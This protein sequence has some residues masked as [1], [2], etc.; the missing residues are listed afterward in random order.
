MVSLPEI[1]PLSVLS[2]Y[3]VRLLG[4][5]PS[6]FKLQGTNTYLVGAPGQPER[7]LIDASEGETEYISML[8][9][10]LNI[11]QFK[12]VGIICTHWHIDHVGGIHSIRKTVGYDVPVYK[13]P[14]YTDEFEPTP[15]QDGDILALAG[16][17]LHVLFTPGHA[18]DHVCLY[19]PVDNNSMF[20]GDNVLGHG[21]TFFSAYATYMKSLKKMQAVCPLGRIYPGHGQL[22]VDGPG[23]IERYIKHRGQREEEVYRAVQIEKFMTPEE[24]THAVYG[25]LPEGTYQAALGQVYQYL[26]KLHEEGKIRQMSSRYARL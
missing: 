24:V 14:H 22:L 8:S 19:F 17:Q 21:S 11:T 26:E 15:I 20:S 16:V 10:Y 4:S 1:P 3:V 2:P 6:S 5:N 25:N 9:T 18:D 7:V 13:V 12:L 23:A